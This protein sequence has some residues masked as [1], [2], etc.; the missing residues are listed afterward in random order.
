MTKAV[1]TDIK[2]CLRDKP[3][4]GTDLVLH[5]RE[6]AAFLLWHC[7]LWRERP[8]PRLAAARIS[9]LPSVLHHQASMLLHKA[10]VQVPLSANSFTRLLAGFDAQ[11]R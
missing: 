11:Q 3:L 10:R 8:L 4:N 5:A 1:Q 2:T 6:L 7:L 9:E